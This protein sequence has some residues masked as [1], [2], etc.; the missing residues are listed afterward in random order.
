MIS[1]FVTPIQTLIYS[2]AHQTTFDIDKLYE[3]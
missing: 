2:N 3:P 1:D